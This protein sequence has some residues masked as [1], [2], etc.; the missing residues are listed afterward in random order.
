MVHV[1]KFTIHI[2]VHEAILL[3][4]FIYAKAIIFN[5]IKYHG[6]LLIAYLNFA[7]YIIPFGELEHE[8]FWLE[9]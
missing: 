4:T 5:E 6:V 1:A 8:I 3:F 9:D 2:H 7:F